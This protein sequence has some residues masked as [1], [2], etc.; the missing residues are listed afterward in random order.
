MLIV[1][2]IILL[3]ILLYLFSLRG[4][5]GHPGLPELRRWRYAHR[6][7]HTPGVPENSMA[8]F[9]AALEAGFGIELDLHLLTDGGLAVIHD[10]KLERT[11]GKPGKVEELSSAQLSDYPLEGTQE[12]IP[13]F[14]Q[15][16]ELFAGKAPLIIELK[17][18]GDNYAALCEAAVAAMEGY[19]GPWC[20]ESFD[21]RCID[22]L[23][24]HRPDIIRGQLSENYLK[25]NTPPALPPEIRADLQPAEL[26]HPAGLHCLRLPGAENTEQFPLPPPLG[27]PGCQLD[28]PH[29][30]GI[31]GSRQRGLDSHFRK[32]PASGKIIMP[33]G[34]T[35]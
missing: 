6:G 25:G 13:L 34:R 28:H 16:L 30:P 33:I 19:S 31:R 18:D 20:M 22:W 8:A 26:P 9:R 2:G 24:R 4:R 23:R 12:V 7:L 17:P 15:V 5:T 1:I 29:P 21:P 11:T 27:H 10:S 32:L 3:L 35:A 14:P